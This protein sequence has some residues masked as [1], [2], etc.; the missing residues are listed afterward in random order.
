MA[1]LKIFND[2]ENIQTNLWEAT[3]AFIASDEQTN[4]LEGT[5]YQNLQDPNTE[6]Y[7]TLLKEIK[8]ELPKWKDIPHS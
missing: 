2:N 5:A 8:K 4:S 3:N 7:K 1:N 6:N